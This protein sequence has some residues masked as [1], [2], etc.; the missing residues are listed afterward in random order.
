MCSYLLLLYD[1]SSTVFTVAF[2]IKVFF[3][4]LV[5]VLLGNSQDGRKTNW[6]TRNVVLFDLR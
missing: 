3:N 6:K 2:E 5:V 4:F 1:I